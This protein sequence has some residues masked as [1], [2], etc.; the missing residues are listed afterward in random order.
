MDPNAKMRGGLRGG[1]E[2][3]GIAVQMQAERARRALEENGNVVEVGG[4][5][6]RKCTKGNIWPHRLGP[7]PFL[8]ATTSC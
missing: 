6:G 2:S 1:G 3:R 7:D 4:V 8:S 5:M